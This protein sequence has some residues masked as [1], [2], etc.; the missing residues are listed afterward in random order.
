MIRITDINGKAHYL[1]AQNI[2]RI[3]EAGVSSQW[4]GIRSFVRTHDGVTIEAT[5]TADH[6]A[7][8]IAPAAPATMAAPRAP[9]SFVNAADIRASDTPATVIRKLDAAYHEAVTFAEART[10]PQS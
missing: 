7:A 4:H 8:L 2:T 9:S 5:E 3:T 10:E 6:I 1:A